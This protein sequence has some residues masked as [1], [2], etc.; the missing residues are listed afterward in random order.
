[1]N[2][3][4]ARTQRLSIGGQSRAPSSK[5]AR[6]S[7]AAGGKPL[8][9]S[10]TTA[11]GHDFPSIAKLRESLAPRP[12]SPTKPKL[13][14]SA[15]ATCLPTACLPTR[16]SAEPT[17]REA[18]I[19]ASQ[20]AS[21]TARI[22]KR[23]NGQ[24]AHLLELPVTVPY[25]LRLH[26]ASNAGTVHVLPCLTP[27]AAQSIRED[28]E[29]TARA[30]GGW[31]PRAVG[32]CTNDVLVSHL[33]VASQQLIHDAFRTVILPFAMQ[34]FPEAN[35]T[36]DS[37]PEKTE[38]FFII[39]YKADKSRREFG[40]HTDHTK[41]TVN[42]SLTSPGADFDAGGLYFPCSKG[43]VGE[44]PAAGV[45]STPRGSAAAKTTAS[46]GVCGGMADAVASLTARRSMAAQSKGL[47]I[48][49]PA[50]TCILHHGDI[51]HAGDRIEAGERL[52]LVAFFY[53]KERRGTLLPK[54]QGAASARPSRVPPAQAQDTKGAR[55]LGELALG[56]PQRLI[57]LSEV[58]QLVH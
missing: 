45:S 1:M 43:L 20:R 36:A 50:G 42:L 34:H 52:Q 32:C 11:K 13:T 29:R 55:V 46:K 37:L 14:T 5:P 12:T 24:Y 15:V 58:G 47:L 51:K 40:E 28:A 35:L 48:K 39:K 26:S 8:P 23:P 22:V 18:A 41:F 4:S 6:P 21:P 7:Y 38:C 33:S 19:E 30:M 3:L 27:A 17:N 9:P 44:E 31:A 54:A 16:E 53:G 57:K 56:Q 10:S 2:S 49:A 25:A